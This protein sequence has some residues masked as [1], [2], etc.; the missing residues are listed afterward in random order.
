MDTQ[1]PSPTELIL[2][3]ALW[4]KT[5]LS[6]KEVHEQV[7]AELAWSFS[8]TRKTL[9]RML[10]KGFVSA[11]EVHGTKVF[12]AE[13]GKVQTLANFVMDFSQRV[14]E[15]KGPLPVSMFAQSELLSA[16]EIEDLERLLSSAEKSEG[17][18]ASDHE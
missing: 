13:L 16:S 14:L 7:A 1:R 3:K 11:T 12:R 6:A 15:V 8:S 17:G 10:E 18:E 2:L 5:P 9:D 4:R